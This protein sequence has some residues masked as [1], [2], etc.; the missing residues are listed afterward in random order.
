MG[1][2]GQSS[3]GSK[4]AP[5]KTTIIP[6]FVF[7][8]E[9]Q[10][11]VFVNFWPRVGD[12]VSLSIP[13][14]VGSAQTPAPVLTPDASLSK[15]VGDLQIT[16]KSDGPLKANQYNYVNFEVLDAQGQLRVGQRDPDAVGGP[17]QIVSY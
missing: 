7:P 14:T 16:M 13:L 12:G 17:V 8:A 4:V 15:A 3:A 9:G 1:M 11:L 10:Y 5:L 2:S 6:K